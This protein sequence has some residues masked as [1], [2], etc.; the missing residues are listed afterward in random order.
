[1]RRIYIPVFIVLMFLS[2]W[3]GYHVGRPSVTIAG[4]HLQKIDSLNKKLNISIFKTDSLQKVADASE[5]KTKKSD[6]LVRVINKKRISQAIVYQ[7][8]IRQV[9]R[10]TSHQVDTFLIA[11]YPDS[12]Y[13][14]KI[15]SGT[16]TQNLSVPAW[17]AKEIAEDLVRKDSLDM[18]N[19]SKDST[20]TQ[21]NTSI[22]D[23]DTT[24]ITLKEVVGQE[25]VS[26]QT[27]LDVSTEWIGEV[28]L[29]K[30]QATKY[31]RQRNGI[32][33]GVGAVVVGGL[34]ILLKP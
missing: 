21:L 32:I 31:K 27:A 14:P 18:E 9:Q 7:R 25:R 17:R 29:W 20:I 12:T 34:I 4:S 26:L 8:K 10:F 3:A 1:M 24:I 30:A 5:I 22:T 28:K 33:A 13:R 16:L 2:F 19:Q 6:S 11:K 23:R 15:D